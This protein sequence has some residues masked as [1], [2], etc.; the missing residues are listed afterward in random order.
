MTTSAKKIFWI[1]AAI[2]VVAL[3]A[4]FKVSQPRR[5]TGGQAIQ[6]GR[7]A[8]S[9]SVAVTAR[10][11]RAKP[12]SATIRVPGSVLAG[13]QVQLRA[14]SAGRIVKLALRE[15]AEAKRGDLLVKINDADLVAQ[16]EKAQAAFNLA[17]DREARQKALLEK[18]IISREDYD[19]SAKDL[20]AGKAD[21]NLL[22]AQID[23]TEIRAP[24]SGRVGLRY[25]SEGAYV[26]PGTPVADFVSVRPIKIEFSVPERYAALVP[27]GTKL[28]FSVQG[29][30]EAYAATV[31]ARQPAIDEATRSL[32]MRAVCPNGAAGVLPGAFAE[33]T[34]VLGENLRAIVVPSEAIVPDVKGQKVF[35]VR[36]GRADAAAVTTGARDGAN[37]EITFGLVEGDT[38]VTSGVLMLR[39]G[40][41]VEIKN[42]D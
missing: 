21:I 13:E 26:S 41:S 30:Q 29:S 1:A 34:L 38:V 6:Q 8:Q 11:A 14:E 33:V 27:A 39:P 5:A 9:Q 28:T 37:V 19:L 22:R 16:L 7:P 2:A 31:Y 10:V 4:I 15:G 42:I 23:K 20:S 40:V 24:F 17:R 32:R 25:V 3:L 12:L 18:G 36:G 35:V